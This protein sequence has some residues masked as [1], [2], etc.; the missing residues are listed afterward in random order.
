SIPAAEMDK[1]VLAQI[2]GACPH[3]GPNEDEAML[4]GPGRLPMRN[5]LPCSGL[6][7]GWIVIAALLALAS[8]GQAAQSQPPQGFT[9]LFNGQDLAGW[10]GMPHTDPSKLAA[11]PEAERK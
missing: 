6:V 9:A 1:V 4:D 5:P 2:R 10:H 8:H 7:R 11:L 3:S